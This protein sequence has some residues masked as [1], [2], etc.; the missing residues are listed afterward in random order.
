MSCSAVTAWQYYHAGH[1]LRAA[2]SPEKEQ[3]HKHLH[4]DTYTATLKYMY[5]DTI[6]F[7]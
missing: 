3:D 7:D 4:C 1:K 2:G 6:W 5:V